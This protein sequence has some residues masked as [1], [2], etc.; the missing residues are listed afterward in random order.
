M[1]MLTHA[2]HRFTPSSDGRENLKTGAAGRHRAM[3]KQ[4]CL[5][6]LGALAAGA[7]LAAIIALETVFYVR[8][9]IN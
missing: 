1:T 8:A 9:L 7:L 3:I 6:A 2:P 5:C 4:F